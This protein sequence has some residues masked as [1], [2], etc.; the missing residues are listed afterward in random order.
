[1][2]CLSGLSV[3]KLATT[4]LAANLIYGETVHGFFKIDGNYDIRLELNDCRWDQIKNTDVI[5]IDEISML[6][7]LMLERMNEILTTITQ[8]KTL[9]GAKSIILIGDFFQLP[10]VSTMAFPVNQLYRSKLFKDNF[11]PFILDTNLRQQEDPR[12]QSFLNNVRVGKVTDDDIE[13][14]K[15]R[16]CGEGHP[17]DSE[18]LKLSDSVNLVSVHVLRKERIKVIN[19]V[20]KKDSN[21]KLI[22]SKDVDSVGCSI[23]EYYTK[24]IDLTPG[25]L[26]K[27]LELFPNNPIMLNKNIDV[28]DGMVNGLTGIFVD[29]SEKVLVMKLD[30]GRMIAIPKMRQRIKLHKSGHFVYRIQFPVVDATALTIHKVQGTTLEKCHVSIDNTLFA[31]GQAYVALSRVKN[32]KNLHLNRFL[33]SAIKVEIEVIK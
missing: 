5:I 4:G 32:S 33:V 22:Q 14:I 20:K 7:D 30:N 18:C 26:E 28:K 12:F 15:K 24:R 23:A 29:A 1:M 8:N 21:P 19:N 25:S 6:N 13:F 9:F 27:T 3:A 17:R 16:I 2:L 11:Q 31:P 10:A